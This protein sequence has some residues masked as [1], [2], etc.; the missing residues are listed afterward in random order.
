[1]RD[2]IVGEALV[3][4]GLLFIMA[5]GLI[6]FFDVSVWLALGIAGAAGVAIGVA[7]T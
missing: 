3:A 7:Q 6:G 4:V 5:A 1:M 2:S